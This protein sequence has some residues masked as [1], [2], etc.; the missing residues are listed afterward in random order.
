[1]ADS[2][3]S[4]QRFS[5]SAS[6]AAAS[7][8]VSIYASL[9]G[10]AGPALEIHVDDIS[11]SATY[12]GNVRLVGGV[13]ASSDLSAQFFAEVHGLESLQIE[14]E[15]TISFNDTKA[16]LSAI[17][18]NK[19]D[20]ESHWLASAI[21]GSVYSADVF[22][23]AEITQQAFVQEAIQTESK[24][25]AG[26][27]ASSSGLAVLR[28][29]ISLLLE[30]ESCAGVKTEIHETNEIGMLMDG[31]AAPSMS[32]HTAGV[33]V[34]ALKTDARA[35]AFYRTT[36][37]VT[38]ILSATVDLAQIDERVLLLDVE[39]PAGSELRIDTSNYMVTLDGENILHLQTGEWIRINRDSLAINI[40]NGS[41][42][43]VSGELK[44]Q[45]RWL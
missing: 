12:R 10:Q 11:I 41:N 21:L 40:D 6:D 24:L 36:P 31:D 42:G 16:N 15:T 13:P 27:A 32:I 28:E 1:M 44:Y 23:E 38:S 3:F 5:L 7:E 33:S 20:L 22:I 9:I 39:L 25:S 19:N 2:R 14:S 45:E 18:H 8:E 17:I 34:S 4:L 29:R 35:G 26:L 30:L 37:F 43:T